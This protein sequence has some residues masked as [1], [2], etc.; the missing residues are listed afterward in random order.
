MRDP[1]VGRQAPCAGNSPWGRRHRAGGGRRRLVVGAPA[2][3]RGGVGT[4]RGGA[5]TPRFVRR[6][7]YHAPVRRLQR[8]GRPRR[9][10]RGLPG[11]VGLLLLALGC[12]IGTPSARAQRIRVEADQRALTTLL[13]KQQG[14]RWVLLR[15]RG[16]DRLV[17][18]QPT[19]TVTPL[20]IYV[21]GRLAS[22][23]PV[24]HVTV[25]VRIRPRVKNGVLRVGQGD[26][27]VVRP[28][29]VVGYVPRK[30][31]ERWIRS[32]AGQKQLERLQV[33]LRPLLR[34]VGDP[35]KLRVALRLGFGR[36]ALVVSHP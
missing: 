5:G 23:S 9:P 36:V 26:V 6:I 27:S 29:G 28:A 24:F 25:E 21:S 35:R 1:A 16:A 17:L 20:G 10:I 34:A 33:D 14:S 2:P 22:T 32:P 30:A 12:G 3:R 19:L 4:A 8:D 15:W 13:R 7:C 11:P 31:L 18:E